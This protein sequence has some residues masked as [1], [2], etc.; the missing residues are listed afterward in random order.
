MYTYL[1]LCHMLVCYICLCKPFSWYLS[2]FFVV[3]AM[4]PRAPRVVVVYIPGAWNMDRELLMGI[5]EK[6]PDDAKFRRILVWIL[7]TTTIKPCI[8]YRVQPAHRHA[9]RRSISNTRCNT[10][11]N[12]IPD[13]G[14]KTRDNRQ[15]VTNGTTTMAK[16]LWSSTNGH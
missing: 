15:S 9:I 6:S 14:N 7:A 5:S 12:A 3:S 16:P 2:K 4:G 11:R 10:K 1:C 8:P 13:T